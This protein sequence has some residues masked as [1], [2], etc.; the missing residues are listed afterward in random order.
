MNMNVNTQNEKGI[1]RCTISFSI[2]EKDINWMKII[3]EI[4]SHY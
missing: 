2:N 4:D 3:I 1:V